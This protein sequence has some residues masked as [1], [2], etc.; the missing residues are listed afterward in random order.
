MR[1]D[2]DSWL[3]HTPIAHR[4]LWNENIPE[5]TIPAY[6]NAIK[7][8]YAC[9]IDVYITTDDQIIVVHDDELTRLTGV[10]GVPNEMSL[11]Q[12]SKLRV[13]GTE[14]KIPTLQEVLKTVD[15]KVPLLIEIKPT[16]RKEVVDKTLEILKDYKGEYAIQSF[17]PKKL[18]RV[19]KLAPHVIRGVLGMPE[20]FKMK[21]F[22]LFITK[23]MPLNFWCKPDFISY[24]FGSLPL[25]KRKTKNKRVL[26]WTILSDNDAKTALKNADN[27]IFENYLPEN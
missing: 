24:Y 20:L 15:G 25:P 1:I 27:I 11:E 13:L 8:G 17:N 19:K 12:I 4:G 14:H 5:N 22:D 21:K 18:H 26:A 23:Y 2:K 16:Q 10:S 3:M 7:H 6:E 9:E